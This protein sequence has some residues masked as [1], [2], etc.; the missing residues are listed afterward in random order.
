MGIHEF[1]L[2]KIPVF[3]GKHDAK[4]IRKYK[5]EVD[6][7]KEFCDIPY[8][9][10]GHKFHKLDVYYPEDTRTPLPMII[11]V[12]GGGWIYGEK[13]INKPY[14]LTL[15]K[16]GYIVVNINYR[17][18]PEVAFPDNLKD[19]FAALNWVEENASEFFGDLDN[20]YITGDSAGGHLVATAL[21]ALADPDFAALCGVK[22]SLHFRAAC[23]NCAVTDIEAFTKHDRIPLLKYFHKVFL[24]EDYK[25]SKYLKYLTTRNN[26]LEQ[27]P[28]L[29]LISNEG[30]FL[31]RQVFAF[32]KECERRKIAHEFYF[33]KQKDAKHKLEHVS[34]MLYPDYEESVA[35]NKAML[36]FF[37]KY[38]AK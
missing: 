30:D 3:M 12:H 18:L 10:S 32:V 9:A 16:Q 11:D 6:G 8:L 4:R 21:A 2:K 5:V 1:I 19:I 38:A 15:A 29:F 34:C 7:I 31:K 26:K 36:D 25:S 37:G 27:F 24:G 20:L 28:P 13:E 23:L 33:T 35:V 14:C 22:S 17:L